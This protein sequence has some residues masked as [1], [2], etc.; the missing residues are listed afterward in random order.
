MSTRND[1]LATNIQDC[2]TVTKTKPARIEAYGVKG[3]NSRSWRRTFKN[4]DALLTWCEKND[5]QVYAQR[6]IDGQ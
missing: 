3:M 1:T 4:A 5:A 2:A 6:Y